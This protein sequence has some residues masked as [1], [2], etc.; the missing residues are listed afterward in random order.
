MV[1]SVTG[2]WFGGTEPMVLWGHQGTH[3]APGGVGSGAETWVWGRRGRGVT[4]V[5]KAEN[6]LRAMPGETGRRAGNWL[7]PSSGQKEGGPQETERQ[8]EALALGAGAGG[9]PEGAKGT[10]W[11]CQQ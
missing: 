8:E 2:K 6:L 4:T 9:G 3:P 11:H 1:R 7:P 5:L 10:L